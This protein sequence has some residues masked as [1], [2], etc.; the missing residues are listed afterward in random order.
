MGT[1]GFL[2]PIMAERDRFKRAGM[3]LCGEGM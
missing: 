3:G 2:G 1:Q